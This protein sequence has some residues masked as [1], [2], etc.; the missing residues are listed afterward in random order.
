MT[1]APVASPRL[2]QAINTAAWAHRDH[3][4]K[5]TD[6]PYVSHV[7]GVMQLVSQVTDDED[8]L[9]AALFHDILEDVPEEYSPQRMAEEFGDRVV[10]LVRGVTKDSTLSSWQDRSDAYLAHL[11]EADDGSVLI[12]AADKLHN[13][14]SIHADLDELGDELWGRFNS[15]KER[16]LWWYRSV[17]DLVQERLPGNP[18]GVELAHQ[19]ERL[20]NRGA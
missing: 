2:I 16:Q 17:A 13:L 12:S 9:V 14:L 10:E 15:G 1:N 8:V 18:L 20:E 7:F 4:R 3:V 6:I 5:G 19:V 11:R